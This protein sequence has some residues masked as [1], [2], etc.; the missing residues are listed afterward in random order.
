MLKVVA[1]ST[2]QTYV[3]KMEHDFYFRFDTVYLLFDG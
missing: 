2:L 1:K 3:S